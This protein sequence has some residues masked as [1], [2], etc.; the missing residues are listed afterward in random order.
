MVAMYW[1][2]AKVHP[3]WQLT[4]IC[5]G[6]VIGA[7]LAQVWREFAAWP[8]PV[9]GCLLCIVSVWKSRRGLLAAALTGGMLLGLYRGSVNQSLLSHYTSYI[10]TV[11]VVE[12]TI[13]DDPS[14]ASNDTYAL[15]VRDV[16]VDGTTQQG[17]VYVT[18]GEHG[19]SLRRS[20]EVEVKGVLRAG[21]GSF[22]ATMYRASLVSAVRPVPGDVALQ[23]RDAFAGEVRQGIDEPSA[24]LG[25]GF[26]LGQKS[27]LPSHLVE[28][29]QVAGLTHIVVA[30][31]YNLMIL[32]R[33]ARR[34]F[35]KISRY[36]ATVASGALIVG[37]IAITGMTPSMTRA[38]LVAALGI[39]MWY[40]GRK[41][42]PVTLLLFAAAITVMIEP[43]NV[44]GNV[45]WMLSF[46]AFA[47]V[48]L[49]APIFTAYFF[50][51][52]KVPFVAQ[53][54]IET[55]SAQLVTLPIITAIFGQ[56]SIIAL[57]A[58][59]LILP[60]IPLAMLLTF[61]VGLIGFIVPAIQSVI[62]WPAEG[63]LS[64]IVRVVEWCASLPGAQIQWQASIGVVVVM[65]SLLIA[66]CWY[67]KW[68]VGYSLHAAS[69]VD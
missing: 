21:F 61:I 45:G 12:G 60:L 53:L 25:V 54:F 65:Y 44:W 27:A 5:A 59:L 8:W 67:M 34:L 46:T 38:G 4:V 35:E 2:R 63:L 17:L 31:G 18:V 47:G 58:N 11:A 62:A 48:M 64:I 57:L 16:R 22:A 52:D 50:G 42:H 41:F 39:A 66:T 30:S 24:S 69:V 40:V 3:T 23:V 6:L 10:G 13:D 43:S 15:R 19:A 32:V 37:F 14:L 49:V 56:L 33:L 51:K 36:L 9:L 28:A 55:S 26:L 20:D 68:R 1:L 7:A 29:L